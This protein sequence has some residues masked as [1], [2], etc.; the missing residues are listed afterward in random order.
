MLESRKNIKVHYELGRKNIYFFK[1]FNLL[2]KLS[3]HTL[4]IT[5]EMNN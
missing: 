3:E 1:Q 4:E 5:N 2:A